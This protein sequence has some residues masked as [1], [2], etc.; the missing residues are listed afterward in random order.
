MNGFEL[1]LAPV[2]VRISPII[3]VI[4]IYSTEGLFIKDVSGGVGQEKQTVQITFYL[5]VWTNTEK[6]QKT[7]KY[8][9]VFNEQSPTLSTINALYVLPKCFVPNQQFSISSEVKL[10]CDCQW[11]PKMRDIGIIYE[12]QTRYTQECFTI[13]TI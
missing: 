3:K 6:V 1:F 11:C 10:Y 13:F 5:F 4:L 9:E 2:T 7:E 8:L 12:L